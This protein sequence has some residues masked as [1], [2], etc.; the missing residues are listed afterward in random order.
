MSCWMS[1]FCSVDRYALELAHGMPGMDF[2]DNLQI[3]CADVAGLDAII[4]R[5]P[6]DFQISPVPVLTPT[7]M[8]EKL[9]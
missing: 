6:D 3:A 5:N 1:C 9:S 4:T 2:E 7:Q 8:L